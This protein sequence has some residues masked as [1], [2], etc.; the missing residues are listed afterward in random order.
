M[1]QK[2]TEEELQAEINKLIVTF[3]VDPLLIKAICRVESSLNAFAIRFEPAY[4]WQYKPT[5]FAN[6]N[7]ITPQTEAVLQ[8]CSYGFMQVMGSVAREYG[9]TGPLNAITW[10]EALYYSVKH[11]S[12][13]LEKYT[14]TKDAI[15]AY[16]AGSVR[17]TPTGEYVNQD[18]V[19]K[20][21]T[22]LPG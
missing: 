17:K 21:L 11:L 7:C 8:S 19:K 9:Y 14:E 16:N 3:K 2:P 5:E 12:N 13:K 1:L 6:K 4:K 15:A 18:Y 22:H 10:Q 20:V